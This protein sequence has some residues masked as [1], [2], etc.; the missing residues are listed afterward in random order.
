MKRIYIKPSIK[1]QSIGPRVMA[2][3]SWGVN[4]E[5]VKIIEGHPTDD[6]QEESKQWRGSFGEPSSDYWNN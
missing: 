2:N 5:G 4:G 1:S 6:S 3:T